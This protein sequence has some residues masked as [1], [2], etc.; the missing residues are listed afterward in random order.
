M[1][2]AGGS[3]AGSVSG[4]SS[5]WSRPLSRVSHTSFMSSGTKY[6]VSGTKKE[7]RRTWYSQE[8]WGHGGLR[9]DNI[10]YTL[11]EVYGDQR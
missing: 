11:V 3:S 9:Y 5:K 7:S 2:T 6:S 4:V 8:N 1:A 10:W